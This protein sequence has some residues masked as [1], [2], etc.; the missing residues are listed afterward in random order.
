[1]WAFKVSWYFDRK[2]IKR[3]SLLLEIGGAV[4]YR[5]QPDER[6]LR[7]QWTS[8]V[9]IFSKYSRFCLT[10]LL[11]IFSALGPQARRNHLA[12]SSLP[13]SPGL[14][15][16][17][18][19]PTMIK[20]FISTYVGHGWINWSNWMLC[21]VINSSTPKQN[22]CHF[23]DDLPAE[24]SWMKGFFFILIEFSLMF[25]AKRLNVNNP[26]LV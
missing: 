16:S 25:A 2:S 22:G 23:A 11:Q 14:C 12:S 6:Y 13:E 3:A 5:K 10:I 8:F 19:T 20:L 7:W 17:H 24:F 4:T 9:W 15:V 1:M 21:F 26:A 18:I